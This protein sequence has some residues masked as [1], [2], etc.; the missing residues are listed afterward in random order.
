MGIY[1]EK[2][3]IRWFGCDNII[4][5][6]YTNLD[7][8][9]CICVCTCVYAYIRMYTHPFSGIEKREN[10]SSPRGN[11]AVERCKHEMSVA[12]GGVTAYYFTVNFL[13]K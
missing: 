1:S 5:C 6:S 3:V 2:Y 7:Y 8:M 13:N 12:A 11:N 10:K 9:V 4:E